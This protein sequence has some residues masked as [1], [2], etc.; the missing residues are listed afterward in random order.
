M[1]V[2]SLV[3]YVT[4]PWPAPRERRLAIVTAIYNGGS[5]GDMYAVLSTDGVKRL[6]LVADLELATSPR[7]QGI[8]FITSALDTTIEKGSEANDK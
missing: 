5:A 1:K 3:W 6:C 2:G 4:Q 7:P 8:P